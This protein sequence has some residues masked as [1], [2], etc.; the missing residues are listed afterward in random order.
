MLRQELCWLFVYRKV[1]PL[2]RTEVFPREETVVTA[3]SL[4][5]TEEM[6]K[7]N[8]KEVQGTADGLPCTG[9]CR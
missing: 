2:G 6:G 5:K 7:T 4:G 8:K 9:T 1:R 3:G